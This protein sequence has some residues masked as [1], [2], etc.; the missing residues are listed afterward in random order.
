MNLFIF[1]QKEKKKRVLSEMCLLF[2]NGWNGAI[3][4]QFGIAVIY[5]CNVGSSSKFPSHFQIRA[6]CNQL[7]EFLENARKWKSL[8]FSCLEHFSNRVTLKLSFL[9]SL[10]SR[11]PV[12]PIRKTALQFFSHHTRPKNREGRWRQSKRE[13]SC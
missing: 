1:I 7:P 5:C 4:F 6:R 13:F 11:D 9:G 3:S 10:S 2:R 8:S 12:K